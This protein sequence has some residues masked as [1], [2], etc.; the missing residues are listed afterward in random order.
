MCPAIWRKS[1]DEWHP[2]LPS[3]FPNEEALHDLVEEAP[4]ML[5]LSEI[6]PL[7]SRAVDIWARI[8]R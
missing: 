2:L 3:S 4:N 1:E 7:M 8:N 6:G 5:P